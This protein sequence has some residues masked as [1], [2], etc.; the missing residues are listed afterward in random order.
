MRTL[1]DELTEAYSELNETSLNPHLMA[2]FIEASNTL[3]DMKSILAEFINVMETADFR[4]LPRSYD[5][6]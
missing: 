2:E 5:D 1:L 3:G 4:R 6:F